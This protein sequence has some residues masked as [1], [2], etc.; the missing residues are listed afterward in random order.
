VNDAG[1]VVVESQFYSMNDPRVARWF[2]R[3]SGQDT[4]LDGSIRG[5][6]NGAVTYLVGW[7]KTAGPA[8]RWTFDPSTGLSAPVALDGSPN[9]STEAVNDLGDVIGSIG[10]VGG[11]DAVI[12]NADGSRIVI[13]SPNPAVYP[14][15]FGI[16]I[17]NAGD[18]SLQLDDGAGNHRGA[19]RTGD[20]VIID[21]PP[22]P[23]HPVS[24]AKGISERAG[25]KLYVAGSSD[26]K[27]G[28]YNAVRWTIDI[29]SHTISTTEAR[30]ERS[31]ASDITRDGT[32]VGSL[33]EAKGSTGFVWKGA[34]LVKLPTPPGVSSGRTFSVSGN[35]KYV[36]G[37]GKAGGYQKAVLWTAP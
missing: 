25:G 31:A 6:S 29:A 18:A 13:P 11:S 3:A 20:G 17:N 35:G 27:D 10:Y 4:M 8:A 9:A 23:T 37:D 22:L 28:T 7:S 12:W 24:I 36:G 2:I 30:T 21:L 26:R 16:D 14:S 34:S 1:Y 19:V 15:A 33:S 5:M 32:V